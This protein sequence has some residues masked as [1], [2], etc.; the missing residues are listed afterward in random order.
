MLNWFKQFLSWFSFEKQIIAFLNSF[1]C[2]AVGC[3]NFH[4]KKEGQC[5][6]CTLSCLTHN[7]QTCSKLFL[8][9]NLTSEITCEVLIEWPPFS[10]TTIFCWCLHFISFQENQQ[11]LGVKYQLRINYQNL[12]KTLTIV[13]QYP[14]KTQEIW[15]MMCSLKYLLTN[16]LFILAAFTQIS[17]EP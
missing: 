4:R 17:G 10:K 13:N 3:L 6:A 2:L 5:H 15:L 7:P 8:W 16:G 14:L 1:T 12:P 9:E 11:L